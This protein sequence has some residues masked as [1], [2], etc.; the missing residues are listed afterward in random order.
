MI[1]N[2]KHSAQGKH[3]TNHRTSPIAVGDADSI[4]Q[5]ELER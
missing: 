1:T 5:D 4:I 3:D 2:M